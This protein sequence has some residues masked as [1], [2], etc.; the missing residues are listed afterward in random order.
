MHETVGTIWKAGF[1]GSE[2]F[3]LSFWIVMHDRRIIAWGREVRE[4]KVRI[5]ELVTMT[6]EPQ[7]LSLL[8]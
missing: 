2:D 5:A 6:E 3:I 7:A 8:L 1:S 4:G